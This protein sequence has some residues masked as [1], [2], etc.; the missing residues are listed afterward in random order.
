MINVFIYGLGRIGR[1]TTRLILDSYSSKFEIFGFADPVLTPSK[2]AYLLKYD[3]VYGRGIDDAVGDDEAH[4]VTIEGK[5]YSFITSSNIGSSGFDPNGTIG[6]NKTIVIDCSGLADSGGTRAQD[7]MALGARYVA[8][9]YPM[10]ISGMSVAYLGKGL[11]STIDSGVTLM[12]TVSC[13]TQAAAQV[14][15]TLKNN[16]SNTLEQGSITSIHAYTNDQSAVDSYSF[17]DVRGRAA[18]Q[19]IIP[20]TT[21][22]NKYIGRLI[23]EYN[24]KFTGIAYRVPV[25]CGSLLQFE[26]VYSDSSGSITKEGVWDALKQYFDN[27]QDDLVSSDIIGYSK[28]VQPIYN[29]ISVINSNDRTLVKFAAIFDNEMGFAMDSLDCLTEAQTNN[30]LPNL[31]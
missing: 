1:A 28:S 2:F 22:A 27:N 10:V 13:S 24:G 18:A 21:T 16:L 17:T 30:Q 19:N 8:Y 26:L 31:T 6:Q 23:T 29:S 12:S 20:T 25:L 15:N 11:N 4:N 14:L 7:F 3:T 5:F 9:F